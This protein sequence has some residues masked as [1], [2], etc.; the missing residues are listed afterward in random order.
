MFNKVPS[1]KL[2]QL[3]RDL[4]EPFHRTESPVFAFT[5][6]GRLNLDLGSIKPVKNRQTRTYL[7]IEEV[8]R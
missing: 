3:S 8:E 2:S 7:I 4:L 5:P 6:S 1:V